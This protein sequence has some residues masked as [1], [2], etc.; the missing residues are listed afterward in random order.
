MADLPRLDLLRPGDI[1]AHPNFPGVEWVVLDATEDVLEVA[2]A[3]PDALRWFRRDGG[4][5]RCLA[6]YDDW[7]EASFPLPDTVVSFSSHRPYPPSAVF[8]EVSRG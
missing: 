5:F 8:G 2:D 4:P 3:G 6:F 7:R 1:V